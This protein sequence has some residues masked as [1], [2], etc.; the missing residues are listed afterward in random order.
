MTQPVAIARWHEIAQ[1]RDVA[2]LDALLA[3]D[4]VFLSPVV[5]TPQPGKALT[6]AYLGAAL[7]ALFNETFR[8]VGEWIGPDS[9]VLEFVVIDRRHRGQRRRLHRLERRR[10]DRQLQGDDPAVE[11]DRTGAAAHGG[12]TRARLRTRGGRPV[13]PCLRQG[14]RRMAFDATECRR[15]AAKVRGPALRR[16][17]RVR[18]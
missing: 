5:R 16:R 6:K 9:A 4:V 11:G 18:A 15:R 12:A 3:D 13:G 1:R 7:E 17:V 10:S 14:Q 2:A 8:Y